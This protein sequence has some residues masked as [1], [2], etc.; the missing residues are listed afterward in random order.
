V[1]TGSNAGKRRTYG[2]GSVQDLGSGRFRLRL[3]AGTDPVTGH[4]LQVSRVVRAKNRS[5]A[6]ALLEDLRSE[7]GPEPEYGPAATVATALAEWAK[8]SEVRGRSPR[9]LHESRRAIATVL[10]PE[11]GNVPLRNLTPRHLD[12][13]Y[14]KL[15]TGEGRERPLSPASVRRY[16]AVLSAA[17]SQA[18]RWGWI[19]TNP[20]TR[21]EPPALAQRVLVVP[22]HD[23]V[24]ALLTEAHTRSPKWGIL[25]AL[26][27]GTGARRGELCALRWSDVADGTIRIRR[28][29]YR[30][31]KER[32]EKSTKA[33][34]E[35]TVIVSP[36]VARLLEDWR[37]DCEAV[38]GSVGVKLVPDAFI[39]SS[40]PDGS[41]PINPDT[42][43]SVVTKLCAVRSEDNPRGL[44][45]PHVHLH[46]LRHFAATEL[47]GAGVNPRDAADLLGHA[48]PGLTLRVYSH[49]TSERQRHA[50]A[51]LGEAVRSALPAVGSS[52]R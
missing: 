52:D 19:E 29:I 51:T 49:A 3:F 14:R 22:T 8:H 46:S 40:M 9:T 6:Q 16:H 35:R 38:A 32:G 26:A 33:G 7:T 37:T 5:A 27:V 18:V 31:G 10:V 12:E 30:A 45:M 20:A 25:L 1:T 41:V 48:D 39:V 36:V 28:S 21:A 4:P 2:T 23:E 47:I 50:A 42:L 43:S 44:G 17:L 15:S 13:L 34:R 11:L 24:K